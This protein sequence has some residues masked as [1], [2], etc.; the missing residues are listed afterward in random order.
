M[1][2]FNKKFKELSKIIPGQDIIINTPTGYEHTINNIV[3]KKLPMTVN[4]VNN[5][6]YNKKLWVKFKIKTGTIID[7]ILNY[8][9]EELKNYILLNII[10]ETKK[11]LTKE[12]LEQNLENAISKENYEMALLI[13]EK[14]KNY[15]KN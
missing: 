2:W 10:K 14:I 1:F 11:K 15:D 6:I 7:L 3:Y 5:D 9:C 8:D 4:V 12:E 13:N